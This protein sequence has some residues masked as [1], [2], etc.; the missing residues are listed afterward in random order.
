MREVLSCV[1]NEFYALGKIFFHEPPPLA[2]KDPLTGGFGTLG[3]K[4]SV[5]DSTPFKRL[6][7]MKLRVAKATQLIDETR[8]ILAGE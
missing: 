6:E 1:A 2:L 4:D 3:R 5:I 8:G 7:K